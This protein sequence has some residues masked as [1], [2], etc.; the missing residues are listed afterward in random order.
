MGGRVFIKSMLAGKQDQQ[1]QVW[2]AAV[3]IVNRTVMK[4]IQKIHKFSVFIYLAKNS[5]A[6]FAFVSFF[7][8]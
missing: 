8:D 3:C 7:K 4:L 1:A 6:S 5:V 2:E